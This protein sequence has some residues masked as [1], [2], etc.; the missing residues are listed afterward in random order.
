MAPDP[1]PKNQKIPQGTASR[2]GPARADAPA[3]AASAAGA[4]A[5]AQVAPEV[6]A[7][8]VVATARDRRV[9]AWLVAQV[10]AQAVQE[11]AGRQIGARRAYPSNVARTLGLVAPPEIEREASREAGREA[12][13]ALRRDLR[14]G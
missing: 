1:A 9:V 14:G 7:G 5:G 13:A 8:V 12:L 10:G 11:A 4:P 6:V 3:G 2:P